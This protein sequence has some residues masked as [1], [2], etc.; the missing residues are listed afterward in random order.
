VQEVRSH[1]GK[2]PTSERLYLAS[3]E[4]KGK[5]ANRSEGRNRWSKKGL[6]NLKEKIIVHRDDSARG[7]PHGK[8]LKEDKV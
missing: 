4:M 3:E 1:R 7:H 2:H 6:K 5:K 8:S